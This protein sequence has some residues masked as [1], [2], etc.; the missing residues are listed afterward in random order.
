MVYIT[1]I[2]IQSNFKLLQPDSM[3]HTKSVNF[4][5]STC[6]SWQS[7]ETQWRCCLDDH[8]VL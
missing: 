4:Q 5:F 7:I 1:H 3:F 8:R 2:Q 6:Y